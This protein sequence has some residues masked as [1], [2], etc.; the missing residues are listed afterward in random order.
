MVT[1]MAF[2]SALPTKGK[3]VVLLTFLLP[4][5]LALVVGLA[6]APPILTA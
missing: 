4:A 3:L 1:M 6:R 5:L 2:M